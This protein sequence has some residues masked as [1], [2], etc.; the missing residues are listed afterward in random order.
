MI[1]TDKLVSNARTLRNYFLKIV[2]GTKENPYWSRDK[3]GHY[4]LTPKQLKEKQ[5]LDNRLKRWLTDAV[6]FTSKLKE[7][8]G[9]E[10]GPKAKRLEKIRKSRERRDR[11]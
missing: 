4:K 9:P 5:Q 6:A 8:E 10:P 11:R 3:N 7:R 2:P 1:P